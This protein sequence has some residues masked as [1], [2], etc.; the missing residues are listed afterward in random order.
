MLR[1]F[2]RDTPILFATAT[3]SIIE[4]Q[5][6]TAGAQGLVRKGAASFVDDLPTKV[7][8]LLKA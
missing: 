8:Q 2:D 3:S 6:I 5:V 4:S 1:T 7:S